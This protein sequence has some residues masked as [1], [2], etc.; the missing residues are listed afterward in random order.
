MSGQYGAIRADGY[1]AIS[2]RYGQQAASAAAEA[3]A[4]A[5]A[6]WGCQPGDLLVGGPAPDGSL[7]VYRRVDDSL[8]WHFS[9]VSRLPS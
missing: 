5:A 7:V 9:A 6:A 4:N 3:V 8:V 1:L 2:A